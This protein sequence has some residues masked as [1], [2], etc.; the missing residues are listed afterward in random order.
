MGTSPRRPWAAFVLACL[1]L[2]L[3]APSGALLLE[4][5]LVTAGDNLVTFD[6]DSG[7]E[8]LDVSMTLGMSTLDVLGDPLHQS[9]GGDWRQA[10]RAE[11][12]ALVASLG[13]LFLDD[14]VH[15]AG[16]AGAQEF[17]AKFGCQ[18][19]CGDGGFDFSLGLFDE[20]GTPTYGWIGYSATDA[21]VDLQNGTIGQTTSS[22]FYG[23]FLVR[24]APEPMPALL[25]GAGLT[26][27]A[28][29][30]P[31]ERG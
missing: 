31:R 17:V 4:R 1:F 12:E 6:S 5:D 2:A 20:S 3:S 9:Q 18:W 27:L 28:L 13:I 10:T 11:L 7:L 8:W 25:L 22:P 26:G 23:H 29:F 24:A 30:R 21:R 14:T 15:A 19:S 16:Q